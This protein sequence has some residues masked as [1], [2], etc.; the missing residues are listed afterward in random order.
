MYSAELWI[1]FC[2]FALKSFKV[3]VRVSQSYTNE[4]GGKVGGDV[5]EN[6][7]DSIVEK[8]STTRAKIVRIICK[9]PN[10]TAQSISKEINIA[11]RNVQEHLRKLQEQGIIRRIGPDKG[12]HWEI[13][14]P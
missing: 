2:I 13:I 5:A 11:S 6:I 1:N 7:A 14:A 9:N 12:G 10:A 4:T 8:L 3:D